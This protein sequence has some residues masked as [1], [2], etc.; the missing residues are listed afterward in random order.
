MSEE[1]LIE[2]KFVRI[3][4]RHGMHIMKM[5]TQYEH[6]VPDRMVLHNGCAGFAE[7]KAP[8]KKP[9]PLQRIYLRK[10]AARGCFVGVIDNPAAVVNWISEFFKH[11]KNIRD[12]R[13]S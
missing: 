9:S 1:N 11:V 6:G 13:S 10:L 4:K 8:G 5:S 3:C 7:I 12:A 2:K